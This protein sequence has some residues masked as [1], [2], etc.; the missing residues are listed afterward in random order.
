MSHLGYFIYKRRSSLQ[1]SASV[2]CPTRTMSFPTEHHYRSLQ[3]LTTGITALLIISVLSAIFAAME[4]TALQLF[5]SNPILPNTQS[6]ATNTGAG[7]TNARR[8]QSTIVD[9]RDAG[10]EP[11]V[12]ILRLKPRLRDLYQLMLYTMVLMSLSCLIISCLTLFAGILV[13]VWSNETR[14]VG[15]AVTIVLV[16]FLF[17]TTWPFFIGVG[18]LFIDV[19]I[20][21]RSDSSNTKGNS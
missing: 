19:I 4:S 1:A 7:I 15:A 10:P 5:S 2:S 16:F 20:G 21:G 13:F 9:K 3:H 8:D 18:F 6:S 14:A 17:L 12:G 11:P